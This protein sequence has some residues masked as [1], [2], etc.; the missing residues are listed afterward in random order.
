M[1]I[2]LTQAAEETKYRSTEILHEFLIR[3]RGE[4][5]G[6][7]ADPIPPIKDCF[8]IEFHKEFFY[9]NVICI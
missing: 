2:Q 9:E 5:S 7:A 4:Y 8:H 3:L 6:H 1:L